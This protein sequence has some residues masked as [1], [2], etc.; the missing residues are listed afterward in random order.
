LHGIRKV[1]NIHEW[2]YSTARRSDLRH[3]K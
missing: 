2:A 3:Q 1:E